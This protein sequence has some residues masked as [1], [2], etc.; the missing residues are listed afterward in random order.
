MIPFWTN[1]NEPMLAQGDYFPRCRVPVFPLD[2]DTAER[3]VA[4]LDK[5][6]RLPLLTETR[7]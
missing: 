5:A 1:V 3:A 2:L 7:Q 6:D 4:E